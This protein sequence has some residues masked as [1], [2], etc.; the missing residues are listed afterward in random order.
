MQVGGVTQVNMNYANATITNKMKI[1]FAYKSNDFVAYVNGVQ[2]ATDTSGSTYGAG[3]LTDVTFDNAAGAD[4]M[5]SDLENLTLFKERLS[6]A[7][8]AT[9][10]TL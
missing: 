6:N 3:V 2:A 4:K 9:L 8:L 5:V 1:A 7:E 10:T